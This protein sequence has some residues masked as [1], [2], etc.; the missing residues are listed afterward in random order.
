M[1]LLPRNRPG[2][3]RRC[4]LGIALALCAYLLTAFGFPVLVPRAER[5]GGAAKTATR[6]CGCVV[7]ESAPSACCCCSPRDGG[8][9]P[10]CGTSEHTEAPAGEASVAVGWVLVE[11]VLRC[12]G[13]STGWL[14]VGAVLPPPLPVSWRPIDVCD[15]LPPLPIPPLVGVPQAP[16]S[17]PPRSLSV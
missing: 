3:R 2:R 9:R 15:A 17:P 11:D 16:P 7:D 12:R 6:P 10:C 5:Q 4:L 1:R 14:S 13:A 8:G